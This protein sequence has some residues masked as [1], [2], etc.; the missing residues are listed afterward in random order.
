MAR[1]KNKK[2]KMKKARSLIVLNMILRRK[3]GFM[4]DR[5]AERGGAKNEHDK[6]LQELMEE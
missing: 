3:S 5:R 4:K 6:L 1:K 2:R